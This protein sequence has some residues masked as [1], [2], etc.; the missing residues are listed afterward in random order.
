MICHFED[1]QSIE[2]LLAN[3]DNA[4]F[5]PNGVYIVNGKKLVINKRSVRL[6]VGP[7]GH[8]LTDT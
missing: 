8:S 1:I 4:S 3:R 6:N 2:L 7:T 5:M